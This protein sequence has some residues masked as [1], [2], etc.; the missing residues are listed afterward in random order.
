[1]DKQ[2]ESTKLFHFCKEYGAAIHKEA[3]H[4]LALRNVF[5]SQAIPIPFLHHTTTNIPQDSLKAL[6]PCSVVPRASTGVT[7]PCSTLD[8][9]NF[10]H[11]H[12]TISKWCPWNLG[13]PILSST[14][15][16]GC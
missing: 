13:V 1:M 10:F 4:E 15:K 7:A 2:C 6:P 9:D 14:V 8:W 11:T 12:G 16:E 3:L 5:W